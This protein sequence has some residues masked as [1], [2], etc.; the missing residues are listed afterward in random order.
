MNTKIGIIVG[1]LRKESY[2]KKI[3]KNLIELAPEGYELEIVPI[4]DLP[5]YNEDIEG[6][7]APEAYQAFRSKMKEKQGFIFVTPEYNRSMP[8]CLKNAMDV[9]SRPKGQSIWAGKPGMVISLSQGNMSG[10]GANHHL[11]QVL[12]NVNVPT[13]PQ[14]EIYLAKVQEVFDE[15]GKINEKTL[16]F[17]Q[18]AMDAY[19]VW[20]GKIAG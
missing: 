3:A 7:N 16:G 2:S 12:V 14:P 5:L 13:M 19:I 9:G 10:F 6:E 8:G 4:G 20:F 1:S 17:L 11:R 18:K 15:N